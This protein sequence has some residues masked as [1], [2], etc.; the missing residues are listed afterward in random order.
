MRIDSRDNPENLSMFIGLLFPD[1]HEIR[2]LKVCF[3][4][5]LRADPDNHHNRPETLESRRKTDRWPLE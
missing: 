5:R 2:S 3:A 1:D 4:W